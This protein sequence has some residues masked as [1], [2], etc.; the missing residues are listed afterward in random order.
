MVNAVYY[1]KR[2]TNSI[3]ENLFFFKILFNLVLQPP[4]IT[5]YQ[6]FITNYQPFITNYQPFITNYQPFITNYQPFFIT[7]HYIHTMAK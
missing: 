3:P 6:P 7:F 1:A 2:H 4:F 5:N